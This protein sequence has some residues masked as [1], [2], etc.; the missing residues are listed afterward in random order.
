MGFWRRDEGDK[1]EAW[2][3]AGNKKRELNVIDM[4][5][6]FKTFPFLVSTVIFKILFIDY[7]YDSQTIYSWL[8]TEPIDVNTIKKKIPQME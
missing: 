3:E 5:L 4:V 2:R 1:G 8:A 6:G 7:F